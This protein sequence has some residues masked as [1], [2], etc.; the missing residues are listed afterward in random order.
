[1]QNQPEHNQESACTAQKENKESAQI[2][3]QEVQA[4]LASE[5]FRLA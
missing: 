1:M 5:N 3:N 2:N 4:P